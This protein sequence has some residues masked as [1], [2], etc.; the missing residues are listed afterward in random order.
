[1]FDDNRNMKVVWDSVYTS[2]K[3]KYKGK[4]LNKKV[5][6]VS[7]ERGESKDVLKFL[8]LTAKK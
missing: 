3:F 1:M 6:S 5:E 7:Q 2:R 8:V 4:W